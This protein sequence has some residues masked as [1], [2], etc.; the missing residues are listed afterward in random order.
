V[1]FVNVTLDY[2]TK[3]KLNLQS[4][5][6]KRWP[7]RIA[8]VLGLTLLLA[9]T[10]WAQLTIHGQIFGG[11]N[12]EPL[13][14]ANVFLSGT[15]KG[16][17]TDQTGAFTL[18]NVPLGKFDLIVSYIGFTTLKTTIQTQEQ[19]TYR[20]LLKPLDNQLDAITIKA[21]RRR[22]PDWT[23]Q[24]AQF[25]DNF[26][27]MSQNANQCRLLNPQV[28]SFDQT[29]ET[30]TVTAQEPLLI[31]NKALG[32][33]IKFQLEYFTYTYASYLV[34]YEGDPVFE[35]LIA[36][37]SV[38]TQRWNENRRKA[39]LGSTMH[40]GRALYRHQLVQ[41]GFVMQK[42]IER[43]NRRGEIKLVA[44][45]GDTTVLAQSLINPKKVVP[46]P[47]APYKILLDTVHS[48]VLHPVIA[49][50]DFVQV[51]YTKEKEPYEFQRARRS[52]KYDFD[53]VFQTSLIRMLEPSATVEA[54]GQFWNPHSIRSEGYWAWE[55]IADDLPFDYNPEEQTTV[56]K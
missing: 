20:F 17:T 12:Q 51:T 7:C 26:I 30:L 21:R 43:R 49:F 45:P 42:V 55:L 37:D 28:L 10:G 16:T 9:G 39:Y 13:P 1:S 2:R 40:F 6:I 19:K 23:K 11:K 48:T 53:I 24:L 14:F 52:A 44:L 38:E 3:T 47:M 18:L 35:P 34:S 46:L 41:E 25:T 31:E 22:G 5:F 36:K 27:G 50:P 54:N 4:H 29:A 33:R 15:T 8:W 56:S 32:Y